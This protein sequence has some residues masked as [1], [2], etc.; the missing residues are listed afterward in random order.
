M[1]DEGMRQTARALTCARMCGMVLGGE[2]PSVQGAALVEL[3]A[4]FVQ[5]HRISGDHEAEHAMRAEVLAHLCE[6][7][8][9]LVA[10]ADSEGQRKQ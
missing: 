5:G 1:M 2:H 6:A 9:Q 4:T 10:L 8:W 7:V 3:V